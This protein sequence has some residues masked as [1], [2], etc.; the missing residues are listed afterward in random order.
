MSVSKFASGLALTL[1]GVSGANSDQGAA[2]AA[3]G[4]KAAGL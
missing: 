3:A 4:L 2:A 1:F